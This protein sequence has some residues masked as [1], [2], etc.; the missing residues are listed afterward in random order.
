MLESAGTSRQLVVPLS[1]KKIRERQLSV[2]QQ[3]KVT[4]PVT[5]GFSVG[6]SPISSILALTVLAGK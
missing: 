6:S 5:T 2:N 1:N 3:R 4:L